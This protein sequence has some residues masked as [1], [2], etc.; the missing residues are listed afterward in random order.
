MSHLKLNSTVKQNF[1]IKGVKFFKKN[2]DKI[3]YDSMITDHP[4]TTSEIVVYM[5][6]HLHTDEMGQIRSLTKD[7][8]ISERKQL[9]ISNLAKDHDL[10]YETV[11]KAFDSLIERNYIA[12]VYDAKGM[13]YEIV[14]YAKY[15]QQTNNPLDQENLNYFNIP[16]H[17]FEEKIFGPLIKH[18]FHKGALLILE[19]CQFFA[20]QIGTNKKSIDDVAKVQAT[21]RMEY[22]KKALNTTAKRV[23]LFL[24]IIHNVFLFKPNDEIVKNPSSSRINRVRE[25]VQVCVKTYTLSLHP[26]CYLE[27]DKTVQK[28]ELAAAKKEMAARI[29]H[30]KIPVKWRDTLDI[31]NSISRIVKIASNLDIIKKSRD[32]ITYAV[33]TVADTLEDMHLKGSIKEIKSIGAFVNKLFTKA[34]EEYQVQRITFEERHEI[35]TDYMIKYGEPPIFLK[36]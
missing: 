32:M 12:E 35:I 9:C 20:R 18:R 29:K 23:R 36:R 28:R 26:A 19:L 15:N 22:L 24:N 21:R 6:L 25:F 11:K 14:D 17:L 7:K 34:W 16:L 30:A 10:T 4:I 13:H 8:N 5:I 1:V 27:N 2:L 31:N 33:S 3:R